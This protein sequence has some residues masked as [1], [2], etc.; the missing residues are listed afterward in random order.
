MGGNISMPNGCSRPN[1]TVFWKTSLSHFGF[2]FGTCWSLQC[3]LTYVWVS[4]QFQHFLVLEMALL[5]QFLLV[6]GL[7]PDS[8]DGVGPLLLCLH[9][10]LPVRHPI[11]Y[12]HFCFPFLPSFSS[13]FFLSRYL[14]QLIQIWVWCWVEWLQAALN[15]Y[16]RNW[17][18]V[19]KGETSRAVL[20]IH[21]TS[22]HAEGQNLPC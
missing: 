16:P 5:G 13:S 8:A 7:E 12:V 6:S 17:G 11:P 20:L 21:F 15:E 10:C 4:Q 22:G 18:T 19:V 14:M 9:C 2:V 3:C 1:L